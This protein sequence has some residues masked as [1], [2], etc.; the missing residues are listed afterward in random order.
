M[1]GFASLAVILDAFSRRAIGWALS[2][3]IDTTL[4]LT[5]LQMALQ[6]RQ[7]APGLVHHSD[8][9]CSMRR[10]ITSIS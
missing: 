6:Q 9:G 4:S 10:T 1:Q 8:Q 5:A 3:H 7:I 2:A